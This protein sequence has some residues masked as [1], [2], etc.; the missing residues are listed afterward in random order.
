MKT[1]KNTIKLTES[2]LKKLITESVKSALNEIMALNNLSD[3]DLFI[4]INSILKE[5]NLDAYVLMGYS[6]DDRIIVSVAKNFNINDVDE[7]L[8]QYG[9]ECL[10]QTGSIYPYD[11]DCYLYKR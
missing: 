3:R 7:C 2:K 9:M 6:T 5:A 8:Q 1:Q 4:E 11:R 10:G